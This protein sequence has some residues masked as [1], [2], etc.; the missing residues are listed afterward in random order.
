MNI[1]ITGASSGIGREVAL[2][3]SEDPANKIAAIARNE[4]ALKSLS[5]ASKSRNIIPI[6]FDITTGTE[7]LKKL[8]N[9]LENELG[10]IDILL[11]NA[12]KLVNKPFTGYSTGEIMEIVAVNFIAPSQLISELLPLMHLGSHVVNIGSMGGFQ[13]SMKFPGLSWY[14]ASK[15]AIAVMTEALAAEYREAGISFNCLCPGAVDT[16]M[17]HE[18]FPGYRAPVEAAGMAEFISD[19][20]LNGNRFFNGKVLPVALSVP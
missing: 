12:G 5:E 2:R 6:V 18:A 11:N 10:G 9:R 19:F 14:S 16:E 13:G 7:A 8:K 4:N 15:A 20:M 1:V 17:F 3:L